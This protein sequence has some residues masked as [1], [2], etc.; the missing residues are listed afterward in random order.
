MPSFKNHLGILGVVKT[1]AEKNIASTAARVYMNLTLKSPTNPTTLE[2]NYTQDKKKKTKARYCKLTQSTN[3]KPITSCKILSIFW[4]PTVSNPTDITDVTH[5]V[6][7]LERLK[8][9]IEG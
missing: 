8:K 9:R 7:S 6:F 1:A 4:G 3:R 2:R 5:L